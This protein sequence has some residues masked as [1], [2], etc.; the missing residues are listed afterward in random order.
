MTTGTNADFLL[1]HQCFDVKYQLIPAIH[2][3]VSWLLPLNNSNTCTMNLFCILK[4][5]FSIDFNLDIAFVKK[6]KISMLLFN[7]IL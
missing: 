5:I 1:N 7:F 2:P 3:I 6:K 4:C